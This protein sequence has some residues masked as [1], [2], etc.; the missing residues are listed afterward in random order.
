MF[1]SAYARLPHFANE[2]CVALNR[3]DF[4]HLKDLIGRVV[5]LMGEIVLLR[6]ADSKHFGR[7]A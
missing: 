2:F 3:G 4:T 1:S 6:L 7:Q 5:V